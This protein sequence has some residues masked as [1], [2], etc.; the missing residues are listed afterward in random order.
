MLQ[1]FT[2]RGLDRIVALEF[3]YPLPM[4]GTGCRLI[5]ELF[6]RQPNLVLV[7]LMTGQILE[8]ARHL[9]VESGRSVGPDQLYV[10]PPSP[11]R[12]DPRALGTPEAVSAVLA[13]QLSAGLAPAVA[14]RQ[15]FTGLTALWAQEIAARAGNGSARELAQALVDLL[16]D[17]EAGPW[18]PRLLRD[19]SGRP[20]AVSPVRLRH[21]PEALQQ[22]C[23]SLGEAVKR[24][25][26][27]LGHQ[28][29]LVTRQGALRR[30]LRRLEVRL[31]TRRAKL[32]AESL[33]FSRADELRRMGEL[34]VAHRGD[35]PRG[36][37]EVTL[38]D[39]ANGPEAT[40]SIPL[41]PALG[42]AAN[43]ERLFKSARRGRRGA[44]RVAARMAETEKELGQVHAWSQRVAEARNLDD[45]EI[46][47]KEMEGVPHL[48]GPQ[49]RESLGEGK[50][51]R[52][53]GGGPGAARQR[54]RGAD[55]QLRR[56]VSSEGF[57]ILVGRD[58]EGN[59]YLTQQ[60]ARPHDLWLHVQGHSGSHV[61]V[62]VP[63]RSA[64]IPRPTLIQAAQLAAYYSQAR[65]AGKVAVDYT[66]RK[67]VRK[68]RKAKPGLV[69][70]TQEK[71][72]IV[73]PDKSL[74]RKLAAGPEASPRS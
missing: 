44:I 60:V 47:Q 2:H 68:P 27:H 1:G 55:R 61:V 46:V 43:A 17:L 40:I 25:V 39:Y 13:P 28:D 21:V 36:T 70:I 72:I 8:A 24:L 41:D 37:T 74:V 19:D 32:A 54:D 48:L 69:T 23:P 20:V 59:D 34:L 15:A 14:L 56:F 63:N 52:Q 31:R 9:D 35:A 7:D 50:R 65:D 11:V 57:T 51:P 73:V 53:S 66:L 38:P 16:H 49:D 6:G 4:G 45:L 62:Q 3:G 30:V 71:T 12:P 22:S 42:A 67:Y 64:S 10:A 18:E 58:T 5:A 33:E 26:N 29:A